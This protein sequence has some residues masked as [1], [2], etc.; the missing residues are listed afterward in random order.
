MKQDVSFGELDD[1]NLTAFDLTP[2]PLQGIC[3]ARILNWCSY[4]G[5]WSLRESREQALAAMGSGEMP[6]VI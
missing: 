4:I 2:L 3:V 1:G 6:L 5:I